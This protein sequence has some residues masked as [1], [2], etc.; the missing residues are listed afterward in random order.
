M[1]QIDASIPL[2]VRPFQAPNPLAQ[3]ADIQ[4][5]QSGQQRN[6]LYEMQIAEQQRA[7]AAQ[8]ATGDAYRAN[9]GADGTI[10]RQGLVG[11]LAQSGQGAAIP[12]IQ[13][14]FSQQDKAQRE[15]DKAKIEA[16]LQQQGAVAQLVS[17]ARDQASWDAARQQAQ[18]MGI[19]VSQVPPQFS[20]QV[21]EQI[22]NQ[23]LTGLQQLEQVW[24]Q[25]GYDLDVQR[26]QE[27]G[28]HNQ[29]AEANARANTGI[30]AGNLN[31]SQ[32]RLA[33]D[34]DAPRGQVVD[35]AQGVMIV[36]PRSGQARPAVGAEGSPVL[37]ERAAQTQE[38]ERKR[39]VERIEAAQ[40]V[41]NSS[42]NLDRLASEA[43]AIAKDPALSRITGVPGRLPNIP[44]GD[45]ADVQARLETL[46]SQAGFAVLQAMRDASKTGGALGNVS[47]FEVQALQNN[48]AALDTN[49][50]PEAFRRSLQQ[51]ID[52]AEGVKGRLQNAYRQQY[53]DSAGWDQQAPQSS[54]ELTGAPQ[55]PA[56]GT[57]QGGYRFKGGN[58]ADQSS[59][60]KL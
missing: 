57:V 42:V 22:R 40:A 19:D 6:R 48:L 46:K 2:Q 58:P 60:E 10:N 5:I 29:A 4:Q 23:S 24:K 36:D 51:V 37:G 1:A 38:R 32:Q 7:A 52:Y 53:G 31:V 54:T 45:A 16:A 3:F 12:G 11:S 47:N 17:G 27:T 41:E 59:W 49:Q 26:V 15:A 43:R 56:P 39:G 9:V 14:Q 33:L 13:T 50:S 18:A 30:A 28:R 8:Q 35:T 55:A 25:R 44:G 34:R 20:P 21:A